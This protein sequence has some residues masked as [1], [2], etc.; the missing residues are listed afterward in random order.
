MKVQIRIALCDDETA[1]HETT[2]KLLTEYRQTASPAPF[3]L[4]CFS[5]GQELLDY[6]D[7]NGSFD[8]YIL[9]I[10]MP[11]MNG[12]RLGSI[13]REHNDDGL[14][15]YLTSSPDFAIES[16]NTDALHYLLKPIDGSQL[17]RCM[18]K[19]MNRLNRF[20]TETISIK[21]PISTRM[22]PIRN[23]LYAERKNRCIRYYLN[24]GTV[25]DSVTFNG[26]FQNAAAAL[27]SCHGFLMVGSSFVVNLSH[28]TEV[29]RSDMLLTGE[30]L[31][32]IPRRAYG[33]VKSKWAD[34]W[35]NEGNI[36]AI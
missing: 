3:T 19:A 35:L 9:D 13:L 20:H 4:S 24:D 29:T 14:I 27:I 2:Q 12:I 31:V 10:I 18:E 15:I 1:C 32:P 30:H 25:I 7:A 17:S 22:V 21:T 34:Y 16:Y 23:I 5:S 26:T 28:V 33:A 11:D 6:I 36:H 8:I